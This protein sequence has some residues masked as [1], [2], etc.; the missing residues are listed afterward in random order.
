MS[1]GWEKN[2]YID[3]SL[4][5]STINYIVYYD[6]TSM[7]YSFVICELRS[8]TEKDKRKMKKLYSLVEIERIYSELSDIKIRVE[9]S[10][11]KNIKKKG[12]YK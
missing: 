4:L 3:K 6:I 1:Y 12:M 5:D 9:K 10:Y 11:E 7:Y 2:I 8:F